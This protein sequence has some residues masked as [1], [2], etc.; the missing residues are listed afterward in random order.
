M[1]LFIPNNIRD[2]SESTSG[3]SGGNEGGHENSQEVNSGLRNFFERKRAFL[4]G[5]R[6]F[7]L[8]FGS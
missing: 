6:N 4:G 1:L 5:P 7:P 2:Q 3:A 8:N